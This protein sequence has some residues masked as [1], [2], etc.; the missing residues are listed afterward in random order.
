MGATRWRDGPVRSQERAV[1]ELPEYIRPRFAASAGTTPVRPAASATGSEASASE[2]AR[3][4]TT[5]VDANASCP[6]PSV[7]LTDRGGGT[8]LRSPHVG[9]VGS[10]K[11]P[12]TSTNGRG[13]R[14]RQYLVLGSDG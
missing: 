7:G 5:L 4:H 12:A 3:W 8:A 10:P 13:I 11:A 9:R 2:V 6:G 1:S 14:E